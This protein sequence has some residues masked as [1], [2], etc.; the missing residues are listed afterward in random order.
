M[1]S[2]S[3]PLAAAAV[4][5]LAA[6]GS[7]GTST[8]TSGGEEGDDGLRVTV[9][10]YPLQYVA[11]RVTA[12]RAEVDNLVPPGG[13]SHDVELTPQQV[14]A[15]GEADLVVH[16]PGLQPAV[17][18][19]LGVQPPVSLV[20]AAPLADLEGDPHFWLD[21]TRMAELATRVA[22]AASELDPDRAGEYAAEAEELGRELAE[23]DREYATALA[24]CAG[25]TLV[26]A[27][28]A[29]G[30]LAERYHL[31]QLGISGIDPHVEPSP[32]RLRQVVDT[33]RGRDVRT[34]FFEATTSPAVAE[35]LAQDLGVRTSVLHPVERVAEDQDYPG[36]MREN[37][38]ALTEGL[39]CRA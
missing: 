6:C 39:N 10:S 1:R 38:T 3:R 34:V 16:V 24:P 30:Y 23:L 21:P 31:Q 13:D 7:T 15:L 26:T 20:D 32:A 18:E 9:S 35:T 12:G 33:V 25:A 22:D 36:L 8:G 14:G 5:A 2:P 29:F 4:L 11:E 19:A 37:L 27:H 17:D 28:E